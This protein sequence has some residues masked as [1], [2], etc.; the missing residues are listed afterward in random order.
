MQS[1]KLI[2]K[3]FYSVNEYQKKKRVEDL[4]HQLSDKYNPIVST[5]FSQIVIV[6]Q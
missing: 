2:Y 6:K 3:M 5:K 1:S 4:F